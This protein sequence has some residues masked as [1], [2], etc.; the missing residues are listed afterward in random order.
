MI[1]II[2]L[3]IMLQLIIPLVV[4]S[5]VGTSCLESYDEALVTMVGVLH[6]SHESSESNDNSRT[7]HHL[8]L[9]YVNVTFTKK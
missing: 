6:T 5:M 9:K 8:I 7:M 4:D 3:I 1:M 2:T